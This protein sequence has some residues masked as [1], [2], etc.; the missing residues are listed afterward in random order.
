M[1]TYYILYVVAAIVVLMSIKELTKKLNA[2]KSELLQ[3]SLTMIG[4]C[5]IILTVINK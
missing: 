4:I 3:T 1:R 5:T 2:Q